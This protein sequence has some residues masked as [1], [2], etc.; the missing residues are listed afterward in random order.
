MLDLALRHKTDMAKPRITL[1]I[2]DKKISLIDVGVTH[3][4]LPEFSGPLIP[5][6]S[7]E[8]KAN[9]NVLSK[10]LPHH[11]HWETTSSHIPCSPF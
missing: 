8:E 10:P 7:S 6:P 4:A 2:A 1:S 11:A 3:Y 9:L 5:S